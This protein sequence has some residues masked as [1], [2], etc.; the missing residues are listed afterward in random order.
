MIIESDGIEIGEMYIDAKILTK[1]D[2]RESRV[3][4]YDYI[5]SSF[6]SEKHNSPDF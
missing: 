1:Q 5:E 2:I 6:A 3:S 4:K